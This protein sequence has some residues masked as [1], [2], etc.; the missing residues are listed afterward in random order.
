MVVVLEM[1]A[2]SSFLRT[3][4]SIWKPQAILQFGCRQL[5]LRLLHLDDCLLHHDRL[6]DVV[7]S[8]DS[9]LVFRVVDQSVHCDGLNRFAKITRYRFD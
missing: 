1:F 9:F 7:Q 8:F 5:V 2:Q 6:S 4:G 3:L